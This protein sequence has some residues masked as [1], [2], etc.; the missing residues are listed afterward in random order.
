MATNPKFQGPDLQ[1][2][3]QFIF[4][5]TRSYRFFTGTIDADTVDMQVSIR[6]TAFTSNPDLVTFEGTSFTIPNPSAY[7]DGLRLF[8][9]DNEVLVKSILTNGYVTPSS[10]LNARLSQDDDIS[11]ILE[12]PSGVQIER[13]DRTVS[14]EVVGIEDDEVQGYNFYASTAPG[15]GA[16]GYS[17]INPALVISSVTEED[18]NT[19]GVLTVDADIATNPDGS[20][21]VD[22]LYFRV[23]GTQED[24]FE[25]VVQTDM[26]Q[27]LEV[28]E[29]VSRLRTTV[30][31]ESLIEVRRFSFV[32]DRQSSFNSAQNPAIPNASFSTILSGDPLYYVVTAVYYIDGVEYESSFSPEVS[33]SPLTITPQVGTFPTVS[34]QQ[35][36]RDTVLSIFRSQPQVDVKPGSVVRDTFIDPFSSEAER[37][38]FL[39]GF[40]HDAQSFATLLSIDDPG[41]SGDSIPVAQSTYKQALKLA[42]Y[43]DSDLQ[44]Q[45]VIAGA[46]DKLA[47]NYGV[48]RR[49]STRA[50]GPVT[51]FTSTR[52][53]TDLNFPIGQRVSLGG[54][55]FLLTS[56]VTISAAGSG[57]FYNPATGRYSASAYMQAETA[58]TGGNIAPS[59]GTVRNA[60]LGVQAL[61]EAPTFG[62]KGVETNRELAARALGRL[63]AVDSGTK[64]GYQSAAVD[65]AGISQVNVVDAGHA[66][67]MRD[68]NDAGNHIGGKVDIWVR[69][70]SLGTVT[71]TFAFTF[72]LADD[73]QFEV[74]GD[75]QDLT[76][77]AVDSR[78]SEDNPIIELLSV[79]S[80]GFDFRNETK[81]YSFDITNVTYPSYNTVQL[82]GDYNDPFE[83]SLA[84]V[85]RGTYRYRTSTL[86]TFTRQPV[87]E[88]ESFKGEV[89]GVISPSVYG[90]FKVEDP[91]EKGYSSEAGDYIKVT[92]PDSLPAGTTIPSSTP[93]VVASED[94][95]ILDGVEY[96]NFLGANPVT[97][98]VFNADR[99]V[100]YAS[101]FTTIPDYTFIPGDETTALGIQ[102][103]SGSSITEGQTILIDYEHDENFV[104]AY[105]PNV[106]VSV[107]QSEMDIRRHITADVLVKEAI[108][109]PVDITG[110][111]VL[112]NSNDRN[113][114]ASKVDGLVRTAMARYFGALTQGE[115]L[116]PS[117]VLRTIDEVDDVSYVISPLTK[118]VKGAGAVV[119]RE[120]LLAT[121]SSDLLEVTAWGTAAVK[122]WLFKNELTA[123]TS[124][125]GGPDTYYRMVHKDEGETT[126][127]EMAPNVNGLPLNS[128]DGG[129]F[130]IGNTG[131]TIP[132][133]TDEATLVA[134]YVFDTDPDLRAA[135]LEAKRKELTRNRVLVSLPLSGSPLD[136][137]FTATYIVGEGTGVKSLDPGPA[138]Y[139]TLG[140]LELTYDQDYDY[141]SRVLGRSV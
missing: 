36:V 113:L 3:E 58:G 128:T 24:Q 135:Q 34:R 84:D 69:G 87:R 22:P 111:V 133:Y 110:T 20:P 38:R 35:I 88:I 138:G 21:A 94:H 26:N 43:L 47:S 50:R 6:G 80:Y 109:V 134:N 23:T 123:A 90:L 73:I 114:S 132:G 107:V 51:I 28:N 65:V 91:L 129:S 40:L 139:L 30:T 2:R 45:N 115:P 93:V 17:Q 5:T 25:R 63:S 126:F 33:G 95:V 76:F 119:L 108:P 10:S 32:H 19:L 11:N 70:E 118:M 15:G 121:Q 97:V 31:V 66:L 140:T 92:Q 55:N 16:T 53:S 56:P 103:T 102:I 14:L 89:S 68:R 27:S 120:K 130:I 141:R 9:G 105:V 60:P 46:F 131:L 37:L 124:N 74:V 83:I 67:M 42:L 101:P 137:E 79:P 18:T 29:L 44:V 100:E 106:L 7:P 77:R 122:V 96:L 41:F 62:G 64:Q 127:Y 59:T 57:S 61:N 1:L 75:I 81:G 85:L 54:V 39:I 72:K 52:P 12:A 116:R 136:L 4:T 98:R 48:T 78:L 117:D 49:A 112:R 8:P 71:D 13:F 82:N 86:H 125:A 104:V 99:T